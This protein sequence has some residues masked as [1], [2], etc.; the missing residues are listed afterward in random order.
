[1]TAKVLGFNDSQASRENGSIR[2]SYLRLEHD[3]RFRDGIGE[4]IQSARSERKREARR[5][6]KV[7]FKTVLIF[8]VEISFHAIAIRRTEPSLQKRAQK[9]ETIVEEL[10]ILWGMDR[11]LGSCCSNLYET[12]TPRWIFNLR[13]I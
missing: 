6:A 5:V 8:K 13:K 2:K 12:G 9:L 3:D 1:M 7:N 4:I 10:R 11:P